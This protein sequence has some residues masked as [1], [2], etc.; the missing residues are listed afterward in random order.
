VCGVEWFTSGVVMVRAAAGAA[1]LVD[2]RGWFAAHRADDW[3]VLVVLDDCGAPLPAGDVR[4]WAL[5]AAASL[6]TRAALASDCHPTRPAKGRRAPA[7]AAA[8]AAALPALLVPAEAPVAATKRKAPDA[9]EKAPKAKPA[10]KAAPKAK[11]EPKEEKEENDDDASD[12]D[13]DDAAAP[14]AAAAAD[15]PKIKRVRKTPTIIDE[16]VEWDAA[17]IG[18]SNTAGP[19]V[20]G[21]VKL[22]GVFTRH[23][24]EADRT[25]WLA[26]AVPGQLVSL[27]ETHDI[28]AALVDAGVTH[29]YGG[30]GRG[31]NAGALAVFGPGVAIKGPIVLLGQAIEDDS[32]SD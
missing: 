12:D 17:V 26:T 2:E 15:K 20:L 23:A 22:T 3:H 6:A 13:D 7:A 5:P 28:V 16:L 24:T 4:V 1:A 31:A 9:K 10:A 8:A 27:D 21:G 29:A 19:L 11:A 14:A 32:A 18:K 30:K 25:A